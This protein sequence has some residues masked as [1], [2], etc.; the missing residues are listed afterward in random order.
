MSPLQDSMPGTIY[1]SY[2]DANDNFHHLSCDLLR[3]A[4]GPHFIVESLESSWL[5]AN[6]Y[7]MGRQPDCILLGAITHR[8]W[9]EVLIKLGK[10]FKIPIVVVG[11]D[12]DNT[13][14]YQAI[15]AG[16]DAV[17]V[18]QEALVPTVLQTV[19]RND[20]R[21]RQLD[22]NMQDFWNVIG[23]VKQNCLVNC[24]S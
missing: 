20:R 2:V 18:D 8:T 4:H 5:H 3:E 15:L 1:L 7:L 19:A 11:K 24:C 13:T 17:V 6:P 21:E 23:Q 12:L 16:A 22:S 10:L 9:F 14:V